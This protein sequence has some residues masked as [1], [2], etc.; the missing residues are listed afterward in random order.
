MSL[1][2]T[3]MRNRNRSNIGNY[4]IKNQHQ[5]ANK[6]IIEIL[7]ADHSR[8]PLLIIIRIP[9]ATLLGVFREMI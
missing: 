3:V 2:A 8:C 4:T 1:L 7:Y 6:E 5:I 9:Q